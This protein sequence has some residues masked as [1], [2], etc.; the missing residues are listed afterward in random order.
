MASGKRKRRTSNSSSSRMR[1][2][3]RRGDGEV[4][5]GQTRSHPLYPMLATINAD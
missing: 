3:R 1:R 5:L 2:R 4:V